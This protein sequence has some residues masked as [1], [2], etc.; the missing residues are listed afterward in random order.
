MGQNRGFRIEGNSIYGRISTAYQ[1][2]NDSILISS[3]GIIDELF[4]KIK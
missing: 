4:G 1:W 3:A 2:G